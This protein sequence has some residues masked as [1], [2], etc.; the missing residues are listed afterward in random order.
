MQENPLEQALR[1]LREGKERVAKQEALVA[2]LRTD[3][4]DT[5]NAE[6]LLSELERLVV[7]ARRHLMAEEDGTRQ[8]SGSTA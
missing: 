8:R 1:H 4:Q 2:A 7:L 5:K 3:G 6:E